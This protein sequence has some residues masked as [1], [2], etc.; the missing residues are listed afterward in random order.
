VTR[1]RARALG[2]RRIELTF[3]VAGSNGSRLPAAQRYVVKQS[4]RPIRSAREF[5]RA[6]ALCGGSC[7]FDVTSV[8]VTVT[9]TIKELR[10]RRVYHYAVAARDNVS[11]RRG[12]RTKSVFARAR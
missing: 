12:P 6:P 4:E 3:R 9:L 7:R 8:G 1:L 10:S 11:G 2:G 5:A